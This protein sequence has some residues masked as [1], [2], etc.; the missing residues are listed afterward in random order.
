MVK[1]CKLLA[2]CCVV[3]VIVIL[4]IG[5]FIVAIGEWSL[6]KIGSVLDKK[7]NSVLDIG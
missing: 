4:A 5:M 1:L 6:K 3:V 7:I 2:V